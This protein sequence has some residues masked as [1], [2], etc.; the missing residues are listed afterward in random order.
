M[1]MTEPELEAIEDVGPRIAQT[2]VDYFADQ[3]NARMVERLREA[4]VIMQ[5]S[6]D[7]AAG[8]KSDTLAGK[9]I[10]ISGVFTH[11]SRDE[12]KN[13]IE[14]HGGKNVGSI[15]KKTDYVLAGENMGP[16]KLEKARKLGIPIISEDDFLKMIGD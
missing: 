14:Q 7:I 13:M 10:I 6:D 15:S 11:H 3:R 16:A 5:V 2:I 9:S 4:G 8:P 1:S 12:Y